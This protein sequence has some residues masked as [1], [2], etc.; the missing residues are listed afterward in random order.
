MAERTTL[1]VDVLF[2]TQ[3]GRKF[4]NAIGQALAKESKKWTDDVRSDMGEAVAAATQYAFASGQSGR[5]MKKFVKDNLTA[6]YLEFRKAINKEDAAAAQR[7]HKELQKRLRSFKRELAAMGD[8]YMRVQ[9]RSER[10]LPQRAAAMQRG[11]Q[12]LRGLTAEGGLGGIQ[13]VG[14]RIQE[15]GRA[16]QFEAR[17]LAARS[18]KMTGPG[19][20]KGAAQA[21]QMAKMGQTLAA[22]GKAVAGFAAVAAV[23]VTLVKL[24]ADLESKIKDM[25]KAMLDSAGAADFGMG[26]AD[27]VGGKLASTLE[28]LRNETTSLNTNFMRFRA[29]AEE[30]QRILAQFNQAGLTFARMNEQIAEGSKFMKN[31]S[32]VTAIALTYSRNLGVSTDEIAQ[33]MGAFA[34]E[35]G[36]SLE[37]VAQGFSIIQREAMVAGFMT[38]RFYSTIVE[39]TSGMAYYGVRIEETTKLL[40]SM[41]KLMGEALGPEMMKEI[42]GRGKEMGAEDRLRE[43]ILKNPEFV[44]EQYAK[45]FGRKQQELARD[46]GK[47]LT[48]VLEQGETLEDFLALPEQAIRQRLIGRLSAPEI[49]RFTQASVLRRAGMGDAAAMQRGRAFGGPGLEMALAASATEVFGGLRIDEVFRQISAGEITQEAGFAALES[50]TGKSLDQLEKLNSLFSNAEA[51][52]S[53]MQEIAQKEPSQRSEED[54]EF[55]QEM[56]DVFDATIDESTRT[57]MRGDQQIEDA[58]DLATGSTVD[59]SEELQEQMTKDQKIASEISRNI[60]GL[61]DIMKQTINAILNDIY[62]GIMSIYEWLVRDDTA[63]LADAAAQRAAKRQLDELRAQEDAL[64]KGIGDLTAEQ[65]KARQEG[66][67]GRVKELQQ[68]IAR[69]ETEATAAVQAGEALRTSLAERETMTV[70]ER[71][72]KGGTDVLGRLQGKVGGA[73]RAR[74]VAAAVDEAIG[75]RFFEDILFFGD[76]QAQL[77]EDFGD[78]LGERAAAKLEKTGVTQELGPKEVAE[79]IARAERAQKAA[80]E[81]LPWYTSSDELRQAE[82]EAFRVALKTELVPLFT[83]AAASAPLEQQRQEEQAQEFNEAVKDLA[84]AQEASLAG[85]IMGWFGGA[86]KTQD[87]LILPDSGPPIIPD[88]GDTIMAAKPGGPIAAA[89]GGGAAATRSPVSISIYGGDTKKIYDVVMRVM[90]E[91]GNA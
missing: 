25:N 35:T 50:V 76:I 16:R 42:V 14:G 56:K 29:S 68:E 7:H 74:D 57:I 40:S 69:K 66:D 9:E 67:K 60:T 82:E 62:D 80:R 15:L 48:S 51:S 79:A 36:A 2:N 21:A 91:T 34:F 27:I 72:Q 1:N 11:L 71:L 24:F 8:A 44:A 32:D 5:A 6:P 61:N 4:A 45:A 88:A 39:V 78:T 49:E 86:K 31:F 77:M 26:Y 46:F 43:I 70:E 33:R 19:A 85:Q 73:T 75:D 64:R 17:E 41:D 87:A 52:L 28:E 89:M 12:G 22:V 59:S 23:I 83:Q 65:E 37:E 90:K 54:Q 13:G 3:D 53:R 30:Q 20:A 38:K 47:D 10:T 84:R 58:L 18:A 55:L 63:R 81:E